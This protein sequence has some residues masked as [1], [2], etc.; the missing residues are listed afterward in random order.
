VV[1]TLS[2]KRD[3]EY[4]GRLESERKKGKGSDDE[5][6]NP[7]PEEQQS[8]SNSNPKNLDDK[9]NVSNN[10]P[11]PNVQ[12]TDEDL[13]EPDNR[14]SSQN[15]NNPRP[16][17]GEVEPKQTNE[18]L[19]NER[20]QGE[21]T[22]PNNQGNVTQQ[23]EDNSDGKDSDNEN[24]DNSESD[25]GFEN[26]EDDTESTDSNQAEDIQDDNSDDDNVDDDN[27]GKDEP[28]QDDDD[29]KDDEPKQDSKEHDIEDNSLKGK[30][31]GKIDPSLQKASKLKD[32]SK[33]NKEDAK[34]E[35]IEIGKSMAKKKV[36]AAV[37]SYLAPII[38]P[39][40]G[41]LLAILLLFMIIMTAA[42]VMNDN[43]QDDDKGCSVQDKASTNVSNSK[44]AKKNA[45]N[46]YK[47][48]KEHVKGSTK[49]G[50]AAWLGNIN[51]ESGGTFS[52]ST[53]QGGSKYKASLAKD[54]SAGGYAFGFAQ[55]DSERRVALLKYAD[56]KNKKWSDMDL[57]L[58]YILNHDSSDSPLIKKLIKKDGDIKSLTEDIMNQWERAGAKE[59]LPKRQA[60]ASKYY[61]MLNK[62]GDSNIGESTSSAGDNSDAG[63]KSGCNTDSDSKVDG[64]L[65]AS[66][67]ANNK[68]G[69]VLKKW[70]SKKE[71]PE[72]YKKHIQLPDYKGVKLK[73]SENIFPEGGNKGQCT[74][75]TW[76][77]MSQL[78]KGKQPTNGNGNS[79]YKAYKS[80]GAKTTANPTV[81]YGF[82]SDP[83]YAG[84]AESSVGHTGVVIGVMDDGKWLMGN[85]NLN[86]EANKGEKRVQTFAL[87]D[88]NKKKDGTTFFSGV[89]GAK[90][91]SK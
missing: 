75:Y 13:K 56:K 81:G 88:G 9:G 77:Y 22:N 68:S 39:I 35:L 63:A 34:E 55:L 19:K 73:S 60:A 10:E 47:Y 46:I 41:A 59:S 69:K 14:Y 16:Q 17:Q 74:E 48:T 61:S 51:E 20:Q 42:N 29:D 25:K 37:A 66:T 72:K 26:E 50:I 4:S 33:M 15:D 31:L 2:K 80:K 86:G 90:I 27:D 40:I 83:P 82:S 7:K 58:D 91:K 18:D 38:L 5:Q 3:F 43:E 53:I 36:M 30:A 6:R 84:A 54:P 11:S 78:Y 23:Q 62:K 64:E 76:S 85:Y 67:K 79:I 1:K 44:D 70:N 71:I 28:K 45:E 32:L 57:Q 21:P 8:Q 52:S 87:V 12:Q 89:G 49:K 24:G 65:G